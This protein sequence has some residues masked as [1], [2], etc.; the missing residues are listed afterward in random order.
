M[1]FIKLKQKINPDEIRLKLGFTELINNGIINRLKLKSLIK[2][3]NNSI[4]LNSR[5]R[6][7]L[8]KDKIFED[9]IIELRLIVTDSPHF[10]LRHSFYH[11]SENYHQSGITM[12]LIEKRREVSG[13][14]KSIIKIGKEVYC[15][16]EQ[17]GIIEIGLHEISNDNS[18]G[19]LKIK[20]K[21]DKYNYRVDVSPN[22][23]EVIHDL[24][25]LSNLLGTNRIVSL[26][27]SLQSIEALTGF[28]L[29]L[30]QGDDEI[31][32]VVI[33]SR[34]NVSIE[35]LLKLNNWLNEGLWNNNKEKWVIELSMF[36]GWFVDFEFSLLSTS[37]RILHLMFSHHIMNNNL[38]DLLDDLDFNNRLEI[39][40]EKFIEADTTETLHLNR[41]VL[42][43]L[44]WKFPQKKAIA[45]L[46]AGKMVEG[47]ILN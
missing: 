37:N 24:S 30:N 5:G 20:S 45:K 44:L 28:Q 22:D 9:K 27:S 32:E 39:E 31:F 17:D 1:K 40:W 38:D 21:V 29:E 10:V 47:A 35:N 43:N 34:S 12:E 26:T 16:E 42:F 18:N 4:E 11:P 13:L 36:N 46:V 41:D 8:D 19:K 25:N 33:N 2:S 15:F 6:N 7:Y 14:L 3:E 23:E